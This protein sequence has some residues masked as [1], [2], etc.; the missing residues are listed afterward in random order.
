MHEKQGAQEFANGVLLG[1]AVANSR[2]L[3]APGGMPKKIGI[4]GDND[5]AFTQRKSNMVKIVRSR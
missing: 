2:V 4:V 3:D 5:S 1:V